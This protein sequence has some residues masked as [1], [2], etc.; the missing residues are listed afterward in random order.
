MKAKQKYFSWQQEAKYLLDQSYHSRASQI[1]KF[2]GPTQGP[3]GADRT[4]VG[5]MMAPWTLLSGICCRQNVCTAY[6]NQFNE[7]PMELIPEILVKS[8]WYMIS[9]LWSSLV[10]PVTTT[11]IYGTTCPSTLLVS[12]TF[13]LIFLRFYSSYQHFQIHFSCSDSVQ[14]GLVI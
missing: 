6:S 9:I 11:Y 4:Q 1:A 5:P 7:C 12:H 2:M 3:S 10:L 14:N 8:V 13:Y